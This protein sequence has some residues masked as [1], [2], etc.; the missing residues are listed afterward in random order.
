MPPLSERLR[1]IP[2]ESGPPYAFG[3]SRYSI[4]F[5]EKPDQDPDT[6]DVKPFGTKYT[7]FLQDAVDNVPE[8]LVPW[9]HLEEWVLFPMPCHPVHALKQKI[10][11]SAR[12]RTGARS[13]LHLQ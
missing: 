3:N 2:T 12:V 1:E 6:F 7:F 13:L 4:T 11:P 9:H 10:Q 5:D 8:Y